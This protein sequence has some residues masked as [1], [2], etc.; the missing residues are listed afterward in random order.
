VVHVRAWEPFGNSRKKIDPHLKL[1][2]TLQLSVKTHHYVM[3]NPTTPNNLST[4]ADAQLAV[5][6]DDDEVVFQAKFE[7]LSWHRHV[8]KECEELE[9]RL[10]QEA[11]EAKAKAE[12][13]AHLAAEEAER[14]R[15]L[16]VAAVQWEKVSITSQ[17]TIRI[18]EGSLTTYP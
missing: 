4:W 1:I 9:C 18:H 5:H 2:S 16:Q 10:A 8:R 11:A 15:V 3:S 6:L 7:E 14:Q 13:A 12:E 17:S